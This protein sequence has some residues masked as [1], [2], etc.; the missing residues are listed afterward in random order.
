MRVPYRLHRWMEFA[1]PLGLWLV[2]AGMI[3][4]AQHLKH[5]LMNFMR[6]LETPLLLGVG[7]IVSALAFRVWQRTVWFPKRVQYGVTL[8]LSLGLVVV[9]VSEEVRFQQLRNKVLAATWDVRA[10]GSHFVVGFRDWDQLDELASKGLIGGIY[11]T[12]RNVSGLDAEVVAARIKHLQDLRHSAGL[13]PLLVAADQEGGKIEHLS[14][15]LAP[16]PALSTVAQLAPNQAAQQAYRYGLQQGQ[17]LLEL[18]INFNLS[19]VVDLKPA[20]PIAFGDTHT[21]ISQRAIAGDK[22][23]VTNV[24]RA[25]SIGLEAAGVQ[26]TLK[27]FP[28]LGR[29]R[30]DTHHSAAHLNMTALELENDWAPFRDVSRNTGAAI[31]LGHVVLDQ[32]DAKHAVSHS[33]RI[34]QRVIR[35]EWAYNGLLITDDLNMGAVYGKGIGKVAGEAINAGVDLILAAYDPD[36]YFRAVAAVAKQLNAG[37][38]D[39]QRLL[40]SDKRLQ[41]RW[42]CYTKLI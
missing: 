16:M 7:L 22:A 17:G 19:P 42:Q 32:L 38:M 35:Q 10:V 25:Y 33:D 4:W 3:F 8:L 21:L 23:T 6:P 14:P 28:G 30:Q 40:A 9:T 29:V 15:L 18:G 13:P 41:A 36:Q 31:M 37:S 20:K 11:V 27:H 1:F 12:G 24:A 26:P 5:P 2:L 34:V 39:K